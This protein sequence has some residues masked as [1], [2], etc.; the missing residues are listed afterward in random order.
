MAW[1]IDKVD[2]CLKGKSVFV[3]GA[4]GLIGKAIVTLLLERGANVYALI[5]D[6]SKADSAFGLS[7]DCRLKYV[8]GDM[9]NLK[10]EDMGIDYVIHCASRTASKDFAASPADVL[11]DIF[12][13]TRNALEFA[14]ANKVSGF[15]YLSTMEVYGA[16]M[17]GEKIEENSPCYL[18]TM[19]SRSCYPEAKRACECLCASY[20]SQ[21]GV[22][23]KVVRLTQT[24][25]KGVSYDDNRVFAEFARCVIEGRDIVLKTKGET[26]RNYV[27]VDDAA[28]AV[29]TALIYGKS[30]EAY[31]VANEDTYCSVYDMARLVADNFGCGRIKVRI[32]EQDVASFGYAPVLKCNL[33]ARKML[34]LGWKPTKGL[35]EMFAE[36]IKD[37][38]AQAENCRG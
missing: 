25:G 31:N 27:S 37:M 6:K 17:G 7:P 30:G 14:R 38:K 34:S 20:A 16:S 33:S 12:S 36:T 35:I 23:V 10:A 18:D 15:A 19:N 2:K 32:E 21:Y 24:F 11:S 5:R 3:T 8:I 28:Q 13:G 1:R 4:T 22:P 29:L 26:M 9:R